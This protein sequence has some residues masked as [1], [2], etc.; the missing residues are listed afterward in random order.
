MSNMVGDGPVEVFS[1]KQDSTITFYNLFGRDY[2]YNFFL[3]KLNKAGL[4]VLVN[5]KQL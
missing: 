1:R 5:T 3:L 2:T 4:R